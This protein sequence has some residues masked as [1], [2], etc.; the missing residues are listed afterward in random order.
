MWRG[1]KEPTKMNFEGRNSHITLRCEGVQWYIAEDILVDIVLK[2]GVAR[3]VCV[4]NHD[5]W[6]RIGW[7]VGI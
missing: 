7:V 5:C 3:V 4:D 1:A 6:R 2:F